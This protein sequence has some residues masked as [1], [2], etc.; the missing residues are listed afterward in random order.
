[1]IWILVV[2]TILSWGLLLLLA[3]NLYR[4]SKELTYIN[5]HKT[6]AGVTSYSHGCLIAP[7]LSAINQSLAQNW[8][9]RQ[10]QRQHEK[11]LKQMLT[12]LTHD[13]KTPLTVASGYVQLF[14]KKGE[15]TPEQL[16][17]TYHNLEAVNYYLRYLMDYNML[18][19]NSVQLNLQEYDLGRLVET[20]LLAAYDQLQSKGLSLQLHL[21]EHVELVTDKRLLSRVIQNLIG[22]WLKYADGELAVTLKPIDAHHLVLTFSNHT[23]QVLDHPQQFS[24][25]F[26]TADHAR[27]QR[28]AGLGLNIVQNLMTALG[29]K[30]F[31]KTTPHHFIVN[32][33]FKTDA[34]SHD[35]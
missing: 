8:H 23:A 13:I 32:L 33:R 25:R 1:M 9:L 34:F 29:G 24:T 16:A 31:L 2:L 17:R 7:L 12:N 21:P 3:V 4:M 6:N 20:E 27:N 22:N 15:A 11:Q 19:E 5:H 28:S 14:Q 26:Y 10:Q 18:Q 30:M 35:M